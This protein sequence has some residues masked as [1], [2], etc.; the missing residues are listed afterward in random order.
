MQTQ[1]MVHVFHLF[2]V[3]QMIQCGTIIQM[4]IQMMVHVLHLHMAVQIQRHG[5]LIQ[6]QIQMM[7]HVFHLFMAVWIHTACN[8]DSTAN[9]SNGSCTYAETYYDCNDVCLN[10]EMVMVFVMN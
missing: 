4:Q 5:T 7:I 1:M 9:T 2:M 6:Q 8:Y 3:V 10:D